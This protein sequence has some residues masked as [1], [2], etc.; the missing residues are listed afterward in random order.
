MDVYA[1]CCTAGDMTRQEIL[2][3]C[4]RER[5]LPVVV[6]RCEGETF[7]P[8]FPSRDVAWK[9]LQRNLPKQWQQGWS[10]LKVTLPIVELFQEK[11]WQTPVYNFPRKL[12]N[13]AEFDIEVIEDPEERAHCFGA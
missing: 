9:F 2:R 12:A 13:L 4:E 8:C 1:L 3:E 7:V 6:M 5:W 10:P 11:G